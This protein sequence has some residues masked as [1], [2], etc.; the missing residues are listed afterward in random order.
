[1][2]VNHASTLSVDYF[3]SYLNLIMISREISLKEAI[4][5]MKNEFFKGEPDMY[6]KM[7]ETHFNLA[8]QELKQK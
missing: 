8:I 3:V 5:Y 2:R 1:M 4:S 7:T 6:G